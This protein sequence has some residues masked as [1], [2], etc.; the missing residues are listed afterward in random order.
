M[1]KYHFILPYLA[2]AVLAILLFK[3]C[4]KT[5]AVKDQYSNSRDFLQDTITYY[6]NSL[7]QQVAEKK[8]LQGDAH[9]LSVLLSKQIDS[10]GQLKRL[11][12]NYRKVIAAGNITQE[13]RIDT[14]AITYR[15]TIPFVFD[16]DW[17][18][19]DNYYTISG[20]SSQR[21]ITI[22]QLTIPNTLSFAIGNKKTGLFKSEYRIEVV[23]SNPYVKTT[24]LDSYTLEV[25]SKNFGIGIFAGYGMSQDG[26]S[27]IVGVGITYSIF[28]F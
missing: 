9:A 5:R 15:D 2:A 20:S 24:G 7:G 23:N 14:V 28:R 10:T 19:I 21:G 3:Q 22:D 11:V 12:K 6:T 16:R 13:T 27:P 18:K 4:D 25:P 8:A 17:S 1:K 26:L